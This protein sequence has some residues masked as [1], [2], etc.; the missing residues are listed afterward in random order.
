MS[1]GWE[2]AVAL[3][4]LRGR[5][6]LGFISVVTWF[7]VLGIFLGTAALILVLAVMSGFESEVQGRIVGLDAH[8][9]V[10]SWHERGIADHEALAQRLSGLPHLREIHPY[11]LDKGM[12]RFR[13]ESEGAVIRGSTPEGL[14]TVL[15]RPESLLE[16][17]P[18]VEAREEDGLPGILVGRYLAAGLGVVTGDTLLL[19]SPTGIVSTYSQPLVRRFQVSGIFELGIYEFDDAIAFISLAE[20]QSIFRMGSLVTGLEIRLDNV[21]RAGAAKNWLME[22]LDYPLAAWTWYD[23]HKNLF[24]MMKLEKWMMFIMLSLIVLVAAFN[25]ISVLTMVTMERRREIGILKA[26]GADPAAIRRIFVREGLLLGGTG[27]LLGAALGLFI[28]WLQIRFKLL[29]LPPDVYFIS[30]FPVEL[31]WPDVVTVVLSALVIS[32]LATLY[33]AWRASNLHPV[34]VIRHEG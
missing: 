4:H 8:L 15:Q 21:E 1:G 3:R 27:T 32:L 2:A 26:L 30:T 23:M 29:S 22:R 5:H 33:P 7:S 19:L 11:V 24:S 25:I 18:V 34:E 10:R 17:S 9:R 20:A 16:G 14:A 28:C 31:R 6:H 13:G 12:L